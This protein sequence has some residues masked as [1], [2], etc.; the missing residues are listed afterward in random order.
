M[1]SLAEDSLAVGIRPKLAQP[2]EPMVTGIRLRRAGLK[3]A[4]PETTED[5]IERWLEAWRAGDG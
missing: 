4:R 2:L 5:E 3:Q 1:D